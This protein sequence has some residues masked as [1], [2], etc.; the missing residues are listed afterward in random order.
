LSINECHRWTGN[1]L[2][3]GTIANVVDQWL[4]VGGDEDS[5]GAVNPWWDDTVVKWQ[6]NGGGLAT[7]HHLAEKVLKGTYIS[8]SIQIAWGTRNDAHIGGTVDGRRAKGQPGSWRNSTGVSD[9]ESGICWNA[10]IAWP[11]EERTSNSQNLIRG[12]GNIKGRWDG[13]S[14]AREHVEN[15]LMAS[16]DGQDGAGSIQ[17]DGV[18]NKGSTTKVR[19]DTNIFNYTGSRSH[20]RNVC[21][22][23]CEVKLAT[24]DG[25]LSKRLQGSL[26]VV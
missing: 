11:I 26:S 24:C 8:P 17:E 5:D 10:N 12:K 4:A 3:R 7:K 23:T 21:Q 2:G 1:E 16:L 18:G 22:G 15:C 14:C 25:G 20:G 6:S 9:C 13:G 19:R